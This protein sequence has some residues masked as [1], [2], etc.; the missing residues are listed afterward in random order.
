M[1]LH[2]DAKALR[3]DTAGHEACTLLDAKDVPGSVK[4]VSRSVDLSHVQDQGSKKGSGDCQSDAG[5]ADQSQE[6]DH[7][8]DDATSSRSQGLAPGL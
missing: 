5:C 1:V 3:E 4:V 8:R 7:E 2:A 6:L